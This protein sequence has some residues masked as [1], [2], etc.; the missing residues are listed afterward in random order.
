LIPYSL[1]AGKQLKG[2]R[3]PPAL[4][5]VLLTSS[6]VEDSVL[7]GAGYT[8]DASFSYVQEVVCQ[9]P[10]MELSIH[11]DV[12]NIKSRKQHIRLFSMPNRVVVVRQ[13]LESNFSFLQTIDMDLV[14]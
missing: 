12:D 9:I 14:R 2:W 4:P 7:H 11:T 3:S 10:W 13:V 5:E 6:S 1:F 8:T